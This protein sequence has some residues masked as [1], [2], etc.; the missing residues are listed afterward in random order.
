MNLHI[1]GLT[2]QHILLSAIELVCS[3]NF[4]DAPIKHLAGNHYVTAMVTGGIQ[5]TEVEVRFK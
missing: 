1:T 4:H 5:V 2:F 3:L